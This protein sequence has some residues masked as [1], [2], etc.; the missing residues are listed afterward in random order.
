LSFSQIEK[1]N[2]LA[3]IVTSKSDNGYIGTKVLKINVGFIMSESIGFTREIEFNV[4]SR[5]KVADDLILQHLYATLQLSHTG[6]GVLIRGNVESSIPDQCSRCMDDVWIPIEFEIEELFSKQAHPE[7]E[8]TIDEAGNID[9]APLVRAE[10]I[11]HSPMVTPYDKQGRCLFCHRTFQE[12][13]Q[14][15]GLMEDEVDPR[16]EALMKLRERLED[17]QD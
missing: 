3:I 16:F 9:L 4:P 17:E 1:P 8:Y 6:E 13:L 15:L 12:V 10:A 14:E 7:M 5:I 2:A 11:L